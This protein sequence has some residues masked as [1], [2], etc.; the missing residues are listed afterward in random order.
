MTLLKVGYTGIQAAVVTLF[1]I[2]SQ[3]VNVTDP[4]LAKGMM[5]LLNEGVSNCLIKKVSPAYFLEIV[6]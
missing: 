1:A 5:P 6:S 3:L 4:K 2:A